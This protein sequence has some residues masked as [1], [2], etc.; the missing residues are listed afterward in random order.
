MRESGSISLINKLL[1]K[2]VKNIWWADPHIEKIQILNKAIS[3]NKVNINP[4]I[5]SSFDVVILM[6]DHKSLIIVLLRNILNL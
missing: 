4:K 2:N 5:L 3:N 1:K 6:T